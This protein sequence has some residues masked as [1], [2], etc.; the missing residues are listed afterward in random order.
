[1]RSI[2]TLAAIALVGLVLVMMPIGSTY[3][4][5]TPVA[6]GST[7]LL[8]DTVVSTGALLPISPV[9]WRGYR[10]GYY[11]GYYGGYW[12][13]Y[14]RGYYSYYPRYYGY[15]PGYSSYYSYPSYC[16]WYGGVKYCS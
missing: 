4:G 12:P 10:G 15:Y 11:R 16:W 7:P 3:A 9:H 1:M 8:T 5:Q 14:Y 13:G 6:T 2:T